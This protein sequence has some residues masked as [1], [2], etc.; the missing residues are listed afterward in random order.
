MNPHYFN[1]P[2]SIQVQF[3]VDGYRLGFPLY[4]SFQQVKETQQGMEF[5]GNELG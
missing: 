5:P 2:W 4:D 1:E 3:F